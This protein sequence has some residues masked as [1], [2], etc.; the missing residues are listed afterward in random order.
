MCRNLMPRAACSAGQQGRSGQG[1][2]AGRGG[3]RRGRWT[4]SGCKALHQKA[5]VASAHRL[6]CMDPSSKQRAC[7]AGWW[8]THLGCRPPRCA[9]PQLRPAGLAGR[10]AP[11]SAGPGRAQRAPLPDQKSRRHSS[12]WQCWL[13]HTKQM[14][15]QPCSAKGACIVPAAPGLATAGLAAARLAAAG[16]PPHQGRHRLPPGGNPA[17]TLT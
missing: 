9:L 14:G 11:S 5:A 4:V 8:S 6:P 13:Q 16:F 15:R 17:A 7:P 1:S 12:G 3:L 10:R 2:G